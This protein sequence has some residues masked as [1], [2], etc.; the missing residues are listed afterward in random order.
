MIASMIPMLDAF[1]P[2]CAA[3]GPFLLVMGIRF[4]TSMLR[5][6]Y[7]KMTSALLVA[8]GAMITFALLLNTP[9]GAHS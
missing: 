8:G 1:Y 3:F 7:P 5:K 6:K 4:R 2:A 9:M